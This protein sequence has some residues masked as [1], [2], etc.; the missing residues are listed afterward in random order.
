M[1]RG[2][3]G[4]DIENEVWSDRKR[5]KMADRR[6]DLR[7]IPYFEHRTSRASQMVSIET[8]KPN[9]ASKALAT[10]TRVK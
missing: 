8:S 5:G 3:K 2:G 6:R 10:G 7:I 9:A 4:R 1:S